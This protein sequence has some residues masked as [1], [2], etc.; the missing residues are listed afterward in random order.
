MI[1]LCSGRIAHS[2]LIKLMRSLNPPLGWGK[3]CP[4]TLVYKVGQAL[5]YEDLSV[6]FMIRTHPLD[7]P[8]Q[9]LFIPLSILCLLTQKMMRLKIPLND[10]GTIS[11]HAAMLGIVCQAHKIESQGSVAPASSSSQLTLCPVR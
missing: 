3:L 4:N 1:F 7:T 11:F 2:D 8:T 9:R 6:V 10:D 5:S